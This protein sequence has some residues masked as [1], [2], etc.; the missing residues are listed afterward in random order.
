MKRY[1]TQSTILGPVLL[2]VVLAALCS[3]GTLRR[4]Q[5]VPRPPELRPANN[6]Q[7]RLNSAT[8]AELERLPGIG[9]VLAERIVKHRNN[10]GL[11]RRLEHL[12]IVPGISERKFRELR[13]YVRLD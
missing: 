7:I 8:A 4:E 9:K 10:F 11:F 1:S 12:M 6:A 5:K 3:C 2:V 13:P